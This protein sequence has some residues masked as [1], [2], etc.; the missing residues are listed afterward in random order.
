MIT[1]AKEMR[2]ASHR[3]A[4]FAVSLSEIQYT[5]V[6]NVGFV[7]SVAVSSAP[8]LLQAGLLSWVSV[9]PRLLFARS[10]RRSELSIHLSRVLTSFEAGESGR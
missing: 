1:A 5:C 7:Q 4:V 10:L 8:N 9:S 6:V 2:A 3:V